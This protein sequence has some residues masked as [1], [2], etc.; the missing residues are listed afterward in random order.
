MVAQVEQMLVRL[1]RLLHSQQEPGLSDE[2]G[3]L[4]ERRIRLLRALIEVRA[5]LKHVDEDRLR[6]LS[7]EIEAL[8]PDEE[9]S[10]NMIPLTFTY[11]LTFTIGGQGALLIPRLLAM[12]QQGIQAGDHLAT[13]RVMYWLAMVYEQAG[14]FHQAQQQCRQALILIE[15]TGGRTAMAGYLHYSL[16]NVYY[17]WNQLDEASDCLQRL[18]TLAQDWQQVELIIIGNAALAQLSMAKGDLQMAQ[19]ALRTLEPL[20]EQ[21]GF[22]NHTPWLST[23]RVQWWLAQG[24]LQAASEWA[25]QASFSPETWEPLR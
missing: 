4:I 18:L 10:W 13:I 23:I 12:R 3:A 25:A 14:Q 15:Q 8:P 11:W 6:H 20:V 2:D 7:Q 9:V 19:K 5:I 21:E 17:A 16:F 1:Q 24:N 22:A